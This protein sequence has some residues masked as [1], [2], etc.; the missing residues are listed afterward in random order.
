M[1]PLFTAGGL[2]QAAP[3]T[4]L[5]ADTGLQITRAG[6]RPVNAAPEQYFTGRVSVEMLQVPSGE[7][8]SSAGAVT[9][10]PGAR[11]HWHSHPL[12]QTLIVTAGWLSSAVENTCECFVGIVVFFVII[13]VITPPSVSIPSDSG[14]TSSSS[15]SLRSPESTEP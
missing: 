9:F 15:T 11:T 13:F 3:E 6:S 1:N 12:G 14:V 7:E 4:A 2:P 5:A 8:R 10:N